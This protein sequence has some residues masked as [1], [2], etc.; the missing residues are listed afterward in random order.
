MLLETVFVVGVYF[1]F[2]VFEQ[3]DQKTDSVGDPKQAKHSVE[4]TP[5]QSDVDPP[6]LPEN[7]ETPRIAHTHQK[8]DHYLKVSMTHLGVATIRQ[9]IYPPI[10]PLHIGLFIYNNFPIYKYSEQFIEKKRYYPFTAIG[11]L[12]ALA[13]NQYFAIG[14]GCCFYWVSEKVILLTQSHSKKLL[15]NTFGLLPS[16]V[17]CLRDNVE[18]ETPLEEIQVNDIV[19]VTI[20]DVIPIDGII[21]DGMAMIDQHALTGESLPAEKRIGETVFAATVVLSGKILV[22]TEKTGLETTVAKIAQMLERS[23]H[24]KNNVQILGEQW[25]EKW[26]LPFVG[27]FLVTTSVMGPSVGL[28]VLTAYF[29]S[30]LRVLAPLG[31]FSHLKWASQQG[32]LVKDGR[33]LESLMKVDTILFD[34][35]GTLT[36]QT[37][38]VVKII[39]CD[40]YG[41]DELLTYA[42][43]AEVKMTHP[44][45][46]AIVNH[47]RAVNLTL[48]NLDDSKYQVGYGITV[49]IENR[50]IQVGSAR[51]MKLEGI[52]LPDK[53]EQAMTHAHT[54]GYS[55]VMVAVNHQLIGAIELQSVVRSEVKQL[56]AYLRHRHGIKHIAIVSGD[57]KQPTKNLA[58]QLG[59]DDYFYDILPA[60]KASIVEQ[61]Q[62]EGKSVCFIG[63]GINDAIA[64]KKANVSISLMGAS[65]IATDAA[66]V[67]LMDGTLRHL[68]ELFDIAKQL[69]INL[70]TSLVISMVPSAINL[71]G[72]FLFNFGFTTAVVVKNLAF[73]VGLG[74]A[75]LPLRKLDKEKKDPE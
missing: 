26:V 30:R 29:G 49:N 74:N 37:L 48:P 54:Q 56:V 6:Q 46:K 33:A 40:D 12:L 28:V 68:T 57:H 31:T 66:E 63:D 17:W 51:F 65:S 9:F 15:T 70:Q 59:M 67:V 53:I 25:A 5:Q 64:M 36:N 47:A 43:A 27:L 75:M 42:A 24:F 52:M 73:F 62:T 61:L 13:T 8:V 22:K 44:I 14:L 19:V 1:G 35:T 10:A 71:S 41:E 58:D 39:L 69:D 55:V 60:A 38:S 7:S 16:M 72:A 21:V 2:R 4:S 32:I 18:V 50:L 20:G 11:S 34:Q 3:R 23:A 45:A